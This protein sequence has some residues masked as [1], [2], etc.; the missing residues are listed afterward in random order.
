MRWIV[1]NLKSFVKTFVSNINEVKESVE[2]QN[3]LTKSAKDTYDTYKENDKLKD[4]VPDYQK[5]WYEYETSVLIVGAVLLTALGFA[6]YFNWDYFDWD[7][8]INY[9]TR[10]FLTD[11]KDKIVE[12]WRLMFPDESNGDR[13]RG[14]GGLD[15][16][17]L[18]RRT[19]PTPP[20]PPVLFYPSCGSCYTTCSHS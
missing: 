16:P 3:S 12:L 20:A 11:V 6:I 14:R 10:D 1:Q 13:G 18:T 8:I 9:D 4:I 7:A 17:D 19:D 2:T 5:H 15:L